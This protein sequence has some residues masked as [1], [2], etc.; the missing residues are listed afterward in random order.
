MSFSEAHSFQIEEIDLGS[1]NIEL[2]R[3]VHRPVAYA[4]VLKVCW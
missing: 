4:L 3:H 2:I 1:S